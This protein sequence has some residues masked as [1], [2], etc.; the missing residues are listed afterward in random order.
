VDPD[1]RA[2]VEWIDVPPD[3]FDGAIVGNEVI[4][5]LPVER[6]RID[7]DGPVGLGVDVENGRLVDRALPADD[8]LVAALAGVE[9]DLDRP[10]PVGYR[11][12][13]C[14]DLPAWLTTVTAPLRRGAVLLADYGYP[15]REYYHPDR[16]SGTLVC[17][18]RHRAHFDP[19]VWPGLTD[20]S[21][22]V[23]FT[24]VGDGLIEAGLELAGFTTQAGFLLGSDTLARL[25]AIADPAERA[26]RTGEFKRLALPGEMGEKF[27]LI[28]ATRG[29][30]LPEAP[31]QLTDQRDRL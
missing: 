3:G 28:A 30:T 11:S 19:Y 26:R 31:F 27:K 9:A 13:L 7:A 8:R 14:V 6:F 12:E 23:D 1:L 22:F 25:E 29:C 5:A 2:R 24:A 16:S 10:L 21:S 20:L 4:D 15:R 17:Q 18:Y